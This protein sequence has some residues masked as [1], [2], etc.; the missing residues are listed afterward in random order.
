MRVVLNV[1]TNLHDD[2]TN[3]GESEASSDQCAWDNDEALRDRKGGQGE[4][5]RRRGEK[6]GIETAHEHTCHLEWNPMQ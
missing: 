6:N 3:D 5:R 2:E 1:F 4:N